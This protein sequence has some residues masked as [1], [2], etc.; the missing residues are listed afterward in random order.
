M[1]TKVSEKGECCSPKVLKAPGQGRRGHGAMKGRLL[2]CVP[3]ATDGFERL[4]RCLRFTAPC[5][6]IFRHRL[7]ADVTLLADRCRHDQILE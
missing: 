3:D 7:E 2:A 5:A 4:Q 6:V 1:A